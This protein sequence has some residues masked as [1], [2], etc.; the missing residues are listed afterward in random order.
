MGTLVNFKKKKMCLLFFKRAFY[1][2]NIEVLEKYIPW[3]K[4]KIG[5]YFVDGELK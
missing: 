5:N 1:S 3:G 2:I 4:T